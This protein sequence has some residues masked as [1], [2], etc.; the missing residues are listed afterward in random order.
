M[1]LVGITGRAGSGKDT[2]ADFLVSTYGFHR[3][4]FADPIKELLNARFGWSME[5]WQ[6]REWK[7]EPN[8]QSGWNWKTAN[9]CADAFSPRSWAQ[10]L[11]T[12]VGRFIDQDAWTKIALRKIKAI[13]AQEPNARFVIPDV[14]FD[15]EAQLIVASG[16]T[17]IE[18]RRPDAAAVNAHVSEAGV[19]ADYVRT[20][21]LNTGT[22]RELEEMLAGVLG[23]APVQFTK[24]AV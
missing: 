10:W 22:I 18:L 21:I 24:V 14:R 12:D 23:L 2:A 9:S 6:D 17:V 3:V 7:E 8:D 5:Q 15:S 4:A 20:V 1:K 16:G 13:T 11:G 19:S